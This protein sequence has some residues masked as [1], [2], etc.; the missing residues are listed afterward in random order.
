MIPPPS[1][2]SGLLLTCGAAGRRSPIS[3]CQCAFSCVKSEGIGSIAEIDSGMAVT[4]VC[5]YIAGICCDRRNVRTDNDIV[6]R[7]S[8]GLLGEA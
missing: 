6:V 2:I 3:N 7:L 5:A 1:W 4:V 8:I